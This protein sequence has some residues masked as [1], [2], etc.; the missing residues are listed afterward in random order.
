VS[1]RKKLPKR[2]ECR[3]CPLFGD[4]TGFSNLRGKG[5]EKVLLVGEALGKEEEEAGIAFVGKTGQFL[6]R[7]IARIR[8][9][10]TG[11]QFNLDED[12]WVTN[13]VRCRPPNNELLGAWYEDVAI[14]NCRKYLEETISQVRPKAIVAVGAIAHK[15]LVG[16]FRDYKGK[17]IGIDQ[18][19]GFIFD[20]PD[21]IPTIGIYHPSFIVRGNF[22]LTRTLQLDILKAVEVARYGRPKR[23][24]TYVLFPSAANATHFVEEYEAALAKN[25]DLELAFDIETPY[26]DDEEKDEDP[27]EIAIED[28]ASYEVLRISFA[29]KEDD[30]I[31]MPWV[32]PFIS[33]AKRLLRSKGTKVSFNGLAYDIPRLEA[34]GVEMG[35]YQIDAMHMWKCYEP[36]FPMSLRFV[37]SLL[38]PDAIQ[39]KILRD[40]GEEV[41]SCKDS[42]YLLRVYLKIKAALI[43]QG[44]WEMFHRLFVECTTVL[45]RMSRR[46][47][48]VDKEE[49][50][51]AR[52][53]IDQWIV[54][55][56]AEIQP[57]VPDPLRPRKIFKLSLETLQKKGYKR[58]DFVLVPDQVESLPKGKILNEELLIVSS[59]KPPKKPK[60]VK[61]AAPKARRKRSSSDSTPPTSTETSSS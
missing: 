24:T 59:P 56:E 16:I 34:S 53:V 15:A 31:T 42:D 9:P 23:P 47:V 21:R 57:L 35:G 39:W 45:R 3:V 49:R 38:L 41:Y 8:D 7:V 48:K 18:L 1:I 20:G 44:R 46:G 52:E 61:V 27:Y 17:E 58:E 32:E 36:A 25:P 30:A 4:G 12:F 60:T 28:D 29:F 13:V 2:P 6:Q 43:A 51:K 19:R 40:Q 11:R 50:Q 54:E 37:V 26:T 22:H 55:K 10:H 33:L 14:A 5:K